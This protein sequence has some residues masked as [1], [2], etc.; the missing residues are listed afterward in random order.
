MKRYIK[1]L[2]IALAAGALISSCD[3]SEKASDVAGGKAIRFTATIGQYQVKATDTSFEEGD[4]IGLFSTQPVE[5]D[6]ARLTIVGGELNPDTP[7]LWGEYQ[8]T[9]KAVNFY[10]YYPYQEQATPRFTFTV[11]EDQSVEAN[12][13]AADLMLASTTAA[14]IDDAVVLNFAHHMSR[15]IFVVDN[16]TDAKVVEVSVDGV[17]LAADVNIEVPEAMVVKDGEPASVKAAPVVRGETEGWAVILPAQACAPVVTVKMDDGKEYQVAPEEDVWIE[18]GRSYMVGLIIDATMT[19]PAFNA[20]VSDWIDD[21]G[22]MGKEDDPGKLSV[23]WHVSL[24]GE[25]FD[26]EEQEDG[27]WHAIVPT[28]DEYVRV[29]IVKNNHYG[30]SVIPSYELFGA[31]T[32]EWYA[33]EVKE[34]KPVEFALA[35]DAYIVLAI[36][37]PAIEFLLDPVTRHLTVSTLSYEWETLGTGSILETVLATYF[38]IPRQEVEVTVETDARIP[39]LYRIKNPYLNW[40]CPEGFSYVGGDNLLIYVQEDGRARFDFN[41]TGIVFEKAGQI[42]VSLNTGYLYEDRN[43]VLVWGAEVMAGEGEDWVEFRTPMYIVLPGGFRPEELSVELNYLGVPE[44]AEG[45]VPEETCV[46]IELYAGMDVTSVRGGLFAGTLSSKELLALVDEV[47]TNGEEIEFVPQGWSLLTIPIEQTGSYTF[48]VVSQGDGEGYD[49]DYVHFSVLMPGEEAPDAAIEVSAAPGIFGEAEVLANVVFPNSDYI[50]AL[51]MD[52]KAWADANLTSDDIYDYVMSNGQELYS[53]YMS[54]TGQ[55][56]YFGDLEPETTY[57]ILVAGVSAFD[58]SAWAMTEVTT[59]AEPEFAEF[60]TGHYHDNWYNAFGPKG[61]HTEVSILKAETDPVRYRALNPYK[62]YWENPTEGYDSYYG[63][64]APWID[65]AVVGKEVHY[66]PYLIGYL[67]KGYGPVLYTCRNMYSGYFY[68]NNALIEEG[69]LNI[70]PT[71]Y[72]LGTQYWYGNVNAWREI[73]LEMPGYTIT[74]EEEEEEPVV[75]PG[76]A[77]RKLDGNTQ[78]LAPQK[79]ARSFTRHLLHTGEIKVTVREK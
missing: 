47:K 35:P 69:V 7:I 21:W 71:A 66:L 63:K 60:G 14:P 24:G 28:M 4:A 38:D 53:Y 13:K 19:P 8:Q 56:V 45:E 50:Q 22:W 67:E 78:V 15:V 79:D 10:A 2:T 48:F 6:N 31:N 20:T 68:P 62:G 34:G 40:V 11:A 52:D 70:A 58:K 65:F 51:I 64:S 55:E 41:D 36:D 44:V 46:E 49:A 18:S 26:M 5:A 74:P 76:R 16:R 27:L 43:A 25:W 77:M 61:W 57:H 39:G 54:S 1:F 3:L 59:T 17:A 23:T 32:P 9:D 33:H 42:Y 30:N 37:A 73:Y 72:I 29:Q 75:E 12:Y